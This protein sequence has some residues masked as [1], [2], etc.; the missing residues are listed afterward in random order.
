MPRSVGTHDDEAGSSS[1]TKRARVT[2]TF[3]EALLGRV[4]HDFLLWNNYNQMLKSNYNTNLA[5]ILPK[6]VYSPCIMDWTVL[7][8]LGYGDT[9]G[10]MLEIKVNEIG[11][12]EILFTSEAWR[13]AFDINKPIYT[14]PCKSSTPLMNLMSEE[15]LV[16][17]RSSAKTIR[18]PVLKVIQKM[19]TYSLC[20]R[21]TGL[22]GDTLGT[23]ERMAHIQLYHTDSALIRK[24]G[25][26][27]VEE[28]E[29]NAEVIVNGDLVTLVASASAGAG[30]KGPS[31]P[32]T[33]T[34]SLW[35]AIKNRFRG[36]KESKKMQKTIL[37]QNYENVAT[38]S[39]EGLDKTY[40]RRGYFAREYRAPRNQGNR[41]KDATRRNAPEDT[42]TTN[43]LVVQDGIVLT[44]SGQVPVIAAKQSSHRPVTS[45]SAARRVNTATP[46][47]NV[48]DAL[49][50][51]YSYFQTHSPGNPR[52]ALHDQ[53]IF[54]SRCSRHMTRNKSYLT[55]YQEINGGFVAFGGN[56]KGDF[57]LLDESQ[58]FLK[59]PRN[60]NMYSFDLKNVVPLGGL[61][62]LFAKDTLDEF[63]LW[64]IKLGH[65]NFK[66]INKLVMGNL[67]RGLPSKLFENY[68]TCVGCHK[69]KQHKASCK[70]KTDEISEILKNFIAG[71]EN[72]MD[73]MFKIIR[74]DNGTEFKNRIMNE[75]CAMKGIRRE[76]SVAMTPQQNDVAERKNRTLI[77]PQNK[78]PYEPF[79]G[80]KPALSFMRPFGCPVTIL[81]TLDHIG[82]KSL[83]DKVA[84]DAG[85]KSTKVQRKENGFQDPEK[86]EATN[87]NNT[88]R[89]NTV[90]L[91]VNAVSSSF[92]TMDPRSE[93]AQRNDLKSMFG[94]DKDANGNN[95]YM[96][97]TPVS[98][99]GSSYVNLGGSI[100]INA[101]TL[102]NADL[103]TDPLMPDL[104]DTADL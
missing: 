57:K 61:T 6:K 2:E 100:P 41:N 53:G 79:L 78:T 44:K 40:D 11:G 52:Y 89:L 69:G 19:I 36:N 8:T 98:A 85:M 56:A 71:I 51:T 70:T 46:R 7:N 5:R 35:E 14:E 37:K 60:N 58:V 88:N 75:L 21:T 104:E 101:A 39:Q 33:D 82:S 95:T 84:D 83:E 26:L 86:R 67:V 73:H 80:R 68:H 64:H 23:L 93:R 74:C 28:R 102:L 59:V 38:S 63:N 17:S 32:K 91:L 24:C 4:F 29:I 50:I 55:D 97:F 10:E 31:L 87:T 48:N 43:A 77:E 90:S 12:D 96:M 20:Q 81:N 65:I 34:K 45:V 27:P 18:K 94:Q 92:T 72:Q 15:E 76:F 66:T 47:P 1:C 42:S 54:D 62:C 30:A 22:N 13:R 99:T 49:P 9:I 16:L 3:K 103:P 25:V